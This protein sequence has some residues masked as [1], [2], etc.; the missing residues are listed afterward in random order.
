ME[1]S[2]EV[3]CSKGQNWNFNNKIL[4]FNSYVKV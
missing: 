2:R 4:A 3:Q 1:P